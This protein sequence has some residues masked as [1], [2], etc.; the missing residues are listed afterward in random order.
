MNDKHL[1]STEF[2]YCKSWNRLLVI[3]NQYKKLL[4]CFTDNRV[5][6]SHLIWA[7]FWVLISNIIPIIR[8]YSNHSFETSNMISW[9]FVQ[10]PCIKVLNTQTYKNWNYRKNLRIK[11]L[12]CPFINNAITFTVDT[13]QIIHIAEICTAAPKWVSLSSS[14]SF[15]FTLCHNVS[16]IS[17]TRKCWCDVL[18]E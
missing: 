5:W 9:H 8:K 10:I 16:C 3:H 4:I 13:I 12:H 11:S 2:L 15:S 17:C 1:N 14:V 6:I 18:S 7:R